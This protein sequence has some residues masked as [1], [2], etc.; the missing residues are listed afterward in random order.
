MLKDEGRVYMR[1]EK[2]NILVVLGWTAAISLLIIK[3]FWLFY[4]HNLKFSTY[5]I[6]YRLA[7]GPSFN[8]VDQVLI[9]GISILVGMILTDAKTLVWT[10]ITSISLSFLAAVTYIFFYIWFVLGWGEVFSLV[11]FGWEDVLFLAII[12]A[13]RFIFPWGIFLSLLGV[14]TGSFLRGFFETTG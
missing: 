11:P 1:I 5:Q 8:F 10:H 2:E 14:V 3:S 6:P 7:E 4:V 9:I 12:N 13:L